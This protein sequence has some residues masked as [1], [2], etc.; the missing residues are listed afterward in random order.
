[1]KAIHKRYGLEQKPIHL[2]EREMKTN[3][4]SGNFIFVGSS[5]DM[6]ADDVPDEWLSR[7]FMYIYDNNFCNNTYLWQTKNPE[8][9]LK[10][11]HHD[12]T[13]V[14][15]AHSILCA[16][17][18]SNR[19]FPDVMGN[20]PPVKHRVRAMQKMDW[21]KMITIEPIMDFDLKEFLDM[22]KECQP[23]Q[24]NIGADSGNNHLPEPSSEKIHELIER[25]K[26]FTKVHLKK[27][28]GRLYK[29]EK[30]EAF[31]A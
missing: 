4:G 27:N 26:P 14:A 12:F 5:C 17:I 11:Y 28:L 31:N 13:S 8:R 23:K 30:Q 19:Y 29:A 6:F 24:V 21:S 16:T 22:I 10:P 3:L 18:E 2:D 25:L 1:M 9:F 15:P 20:A 7:I